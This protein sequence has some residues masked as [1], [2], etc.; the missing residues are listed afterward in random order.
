MNLLLILPVLI[1][2]LTAIL[3]VLFRDS[4]GA[5]R[6]I[7][8][9]GAW[10]LFVAAAALVNDVW[11]N[12][13]QAAQMGNWPAPYGITLVADLFSAV[14]VLL[15][16]IIAAAVAMY[17]LVSIDAKREEF[18]YHPLYHFLLM[19]VCGAFLTGDLFN[20]YVWFEVMLMSSFVLMALGGERG[21]MEGAIKYVTLNLI[22]SAMFLSALGLLY[23]MAGTLNMADLA[24]KFS[25]ISASQPQGIVTTLAMLFMVAFGIKAAVFPLFFWLPASYHTPPVAVSALFAGLLTKVGVYALIRVF[26]LIFV[27]DVGYTHTLILILAGLTMVT[28]VLGAVAQ[29]EFRRVL[30]FH[31]ISQIG[32]MIMGLG[33]FT[34]L[35]LAGSVFYIAHHI[36][37]KTNLFLISGVVERLGGS[38][39]LEKARRVVSGAAGPGVVV[40]RPGHVTGWAASAFRVLCQT[41]SGARRAGGR[42]ICHGGGLPR[43][44]IA[45]AVLDAQVVGG[46]FL[47][48][49]SGG[50]WKRRQSA[51]RTAAVAVSDC[52]PGCDHG[53]H[54]SWRR[55]GFWICLAGRRPVDGSKYLHPGS[56][57]RRAMNYLFMN[58]LLALAWA[59]LTGTFNPTNLIFGFAAGIRRVVRCPPRAGTD[60]LLPKGLAGDQFAL[61]FLWELIIANLRVARDVLTPQDYMKPRVIAI[62]LDARTDAE[63][64]ALAYVISLTPGTL[65]LDVS[66]DR[67][68]LFIHALYAPDADAVRRE[69]KQGFERRLL[70]LM[71]GSKS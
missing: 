25:T 27:N 8:S 17:S 45:D 11:R 50:G 31:I 22:S 63:I 65:S 59:A 26:T 29:N 56:H 28:G 33:L 67:R 4:R 35:A 61:F 32:Y 13:I 18:G 23:A 30:S 5:Q 55:R 9:L 7:S 21:Q 20:L 51:C 48:T 70:E 42:A 14:M 46:G 37:V 49:R 36:I 38:P 10:A 3:A 57:G 44:G 39:N 68:T 40:P 66:T 47:E 43:R 24:Y 1:P 53:G 69:I 64:T 34:P 60:R 2:M 15:A 16:G 6:L 41:E 71:R 62:P 54:R 52:L 19:G 12:G 58:T